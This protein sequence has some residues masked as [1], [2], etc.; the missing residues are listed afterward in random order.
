L[1]T[2]ATLLIAAV[3]SL[4]YGD[5]ERDSVYFGYSDFG[6]YD[7]L[8][9]RMNFIQKDSLSNISLTGNNSKTYYEDYAKNDIGIKGDI[10]VRHKFMKYG[11]ILSSDYMSNSSVTRPTQSDISILPMVGYED[12]GMNV[13]AAFGYVGKSDVLSQKTGRSVLIDGNYF[14]S[15][16]FDNLSVNASLEGNDVYSDLNYGSASDLTYT[17][18]FEE[19]FG[20]FTVN[21]RGNINQYSF[22]DLQS[23]EYRIKRYEYDISSGFL[24]IASENI[25]NNSEI[26]FYSRNR[27]SYRDGESIGF[28]SNSNFQ[29]S[30][31][32]FYNRDGFSGSMRLDFDTGSD[33]FSV[34]YDEND[35]SL[36]YYNFAISPHL[37]YR[38]SDYRFTLSGRYVKHEYKSLTISNL[39]DRDIIKLMVT[40]EAAYSRYGFL[41]VV[42]SFPL[43][44]YRLINISSQR[45]INNYIDRAVASNT[46]LRYDLNEKLYLT[47]NIKFRSYYR[48][49]DYDET[50]SNSFV[51]KNYSAA[52]TVSYSFSRTADLKLSARY[53][54]EEF[55]NFNFDSF[56][57]NP[58][59]FKHH[60]YS[61]ASFLYRMFT[62]FLFRTEYY[63]YEIDSYDFDQEDFSKDDLKR[64]YIS[65]GPKLGMEY[66]K[67]NFYLFSGL[68]IENYRLTDRQIKLKIESY[69][70]FN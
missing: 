16:K 69:L 66:R 2:A 59:N 60:Y 5:A 4:C 31:E 11:L 46:D 38:Y 37:N 51:I 3:F 42:Q 64:V 18:R 63:Y 15:E 22:L 20:S 19:G 62:G 9:M 39:E 7:I 61:S 14:Y 53:I 21:G 34:D 12:N 58:V 44:Y 65:H 27:D 36:S 55:G 35:K 13:R 47:G 6:P 49:Y 24:Y 45:S 10:S 56:T 32:I 28:N 48:S 54:Y 50:Y 17:K 67:K 23:A 25:R 30:D 43:E 29:I 40:P 26:G 68:E 52:D 8:S 33:K 57:E 1:R 70:S 41:T